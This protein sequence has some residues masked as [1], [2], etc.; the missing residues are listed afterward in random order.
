MRK[1]RPL[2]GVRVLAF[3]AAFSLP[4]GTR[5]LAELGAE[6]VQVARPGAGDGGY[7]S[8]VDGA[9]LSKALVSLNLKDA[10]GLALARQL[11]LS[12]D[13]VCNNFRPAV[14]KRYGL[15]YETLRQEKPAIIV[16]QLSGYGGPGPWQHFG[17]FG[18]STE[19]AG[20]LWMQMG[21]ADDPP[22]Q[23]GSGVYADQVGGRYAAFAIVAALAERTR[24]G[25]GQEI[26]LSMQEGI[27][28]LLGDALLRTA[29]TGTPPPRTGN[30]SETHAPEGIYAC[31]GNSGNAAN[32][33]SAIRNPQSD[34]WLALSILTDQQWC[35][36]RD[37]LGDPCL[38]DP[39][40]ESVTERQRR[41]DEIDAC[42]SAWTRRHEK[43]A[44][45]EIL[46]ARGIPAGPVQRT[47]EL[48]FD[49]QYAARG[50]FQIVKHPR[51]VLG[52]DAHPHLTLP[53]RV[54]GAERAAL[55][56][57]EGPGADN[58]RILKRWLGLSA[59]E[60][61]ALERSGALVPPRPF[62]V[63]E[64]PLLGARGA[65]VEPDFAERLRLPRA[66]KTEQTPAVEGAR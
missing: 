60:V 63:N 65:A 7:I 8:W 58:R 16:L 12:A 29:V 51:P 14:M 6:V 35:A 9:A 30:R 21:G 25:V 4:S 15:D 26:D 39:T 11:A 45:A 5:T 33:Q 36:L 62:V 17:A 44:A 42:I 31:L 41:H 28:H 59:R 66:T 40:L 1:Y 56:A 2:R 50:S 57:S 64:P 43:N 18:P 47:S 3:E 32:P 34:E 37:L 24:T 49:P 10:G 38:A 54:A 22:M 55:T 46:Q 27:I 19:A 20:G 53:W 52:Y 13:V 61:R 23:P 48:P